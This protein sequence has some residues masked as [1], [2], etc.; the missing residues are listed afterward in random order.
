MS[1]DFCPV[2]CAC[3]WFPQITHT[4][5]ASVCK[6]GT[7]HHMQ[8]PLTRIQERNRPARTELSWL[9]QMR[10][11]LI[12]CGGNVAYASGSEEPPQIEC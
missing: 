5:G 6:R 10:D 3:V 1:S 8:P 4:K 7:A 2:A 11:H 12:C 9:G